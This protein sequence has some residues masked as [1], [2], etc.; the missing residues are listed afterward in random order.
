M[1]LIIIYFSLSISGLILI[2]L[3]G[4][5]TSLSLESKL[6]KISLSPISLAGLASYMVS[7]MLW[8]VIIQL[9]DVSYIVPFST[10]IITLLLFVSGI[11]FFKETFSFRKL[12]GLI[13]I[14]IGVT[15]IHV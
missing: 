1:G 10:G 6:I 4:A 9:Y 13:F 15:L 5:G 14:V 3:G 2:K 11:V 7:F 8:I 12:V